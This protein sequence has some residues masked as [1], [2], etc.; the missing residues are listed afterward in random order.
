[1]EEETY[2]TASE[3]AKQ[4]IS[5]EMRIKTCPN[6]RDPISRLVG[7]IGVCGTTEFEENLLRNTEFWQFLDGRRDKIDIELVKFD[8]NGGF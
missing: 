6:G 1:M 3:R 5:T 7:V 2:S 4:G 8:R